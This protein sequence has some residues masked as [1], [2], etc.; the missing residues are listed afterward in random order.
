[1]IRA[2]ARA[3]RNSDSCGW[4]V[5]TARRGPG[6]PV[7]RDALNR[8]APRQEPWAPHWAQTRSRYGCATQR[9]RGSSAGAENRP[10]DGPALSWARRRGYGSSVTTA[11]SISHGSGRSDGLK[12]TWIVQDFVPAGAGPDVGG[13]CGSL[14]CASG[15]DGVAD[16][17][18][19]R[20]FRGAGRLK[21]R[22]HDSELLIERVGDPVEQ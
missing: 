10:E 1:M 9:R 18:L 14:A 13:A 22:H 8:P 12:R 19:T 16:G 6:S 15:S 2:M 11:T 4:P 3:S 21:R 7:G 5:T 17:T 20:A